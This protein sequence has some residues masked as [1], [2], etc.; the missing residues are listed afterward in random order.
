MKSGKILNSMG[1]LSRLFFYVLYLKRPPW[2]TGISPPELINFIATHPPGFALDLGCGTGTN[3][4]TMARAGWQVTGVDFVGRAIRI[5]REKAHLAGVKV[6]FIVEDVTQLK[7]LNTTYDF[8][9]DIGCFHNL[10][11]KQKETY[12]Q[13]LSRLLKPRGF[14][15]MYGF[16]WQPSLSPQGIRPEDLSRLKTDLLLI[17]R[18]DGT[19]RGDQPSVWLTYQ[20]N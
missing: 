6:D 3:A 18:E 4:I 7:S 2:D 5:A 14:I 1:I 12:I 19:D 15:L 17:N 16:I 9:L 13:N 11:E 20:I 8:I 10:T